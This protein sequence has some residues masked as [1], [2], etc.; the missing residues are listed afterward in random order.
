MSQVLMAVWLTSLPLDFK[1]L[2]SNPGGD[3]PFLINRDR[4]D[5]EK[6][7]VVKRF[8]YSTQTGKN[9]PPAKMRT[10]DILVKICHGLYENLLHSF[11]LHLIL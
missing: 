5:Q 2:D 10:H 3:I 7:Y 4:Y 6:L 9:P 11:Q 1:F 8:V